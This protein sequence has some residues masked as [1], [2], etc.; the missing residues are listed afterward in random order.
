MEQTWEAVL[1]KEFPAGCAPG[2]IYP[3][4][5]TEQDL[6]HKERKKFLGGFVDAE[7]IQRFSWNGEC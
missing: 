4:D 1:G 7:L 5:K 2:G 3:M 6:C